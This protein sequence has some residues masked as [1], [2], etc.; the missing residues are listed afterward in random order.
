MT[1]EQVEQYQTLD[2]I[3]NEECSRVAGILEDYEVY[4]D[5][6]ETSDITYAKEFSI[7]GVVV[8]WNGDE[9]WNYGGHEYHSGNFPVSYLSMSE[10]ELRAAA[11]KENETYLAEVRKK[12]KERQ[13]AQDK[14]DYEKYQRLKEKFGK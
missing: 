2:N 13:K 9:Y 14:A 6:W 1:K 8:D 10:K 3:F 12:K 5:R 7:D 4:T 11:E